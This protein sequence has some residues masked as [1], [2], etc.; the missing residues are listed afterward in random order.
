MFL[1]FSGSWHNDN[2]TLKHVSSSSEMFWSN[3]KSA[4]CQQLSTWF[5]MST[6]VNMIQHVNII[7]HMSDY[8]SICQHMSTIV[9]IC[10]H[11][12]AYCQHLSTHVIICQ[13]MSTIVNNYQPKLVKEAA[14]T[15]QTS[16]GFVVRARWNMARLQAS[17]WSPRMHHMSH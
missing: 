4:I 17:F 12:S 7:Q 15:G 6:Y 2:L 16:Q 14:G 3:Q 8:V 5:N 11:M 9:N 1:V 10:Q 13:H